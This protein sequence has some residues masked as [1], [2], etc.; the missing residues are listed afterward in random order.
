MLVA[1]A[2]ESPARL[3]VRRM[4]ELRATPLAGTEGAQAPFF[5]PDGESVGFFAQGA[6]KKIAVAGGATVTLDQVSQPIGGTW[7][8]RDTIVYVPAPGQIREVSANGGEAST[9]PRR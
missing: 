9:S 8:D 4:N 1:R 6:L 7:T 3:Y 5:S 2:A